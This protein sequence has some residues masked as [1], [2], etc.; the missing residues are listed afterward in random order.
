MAIMGTPG[1]LFG[2][3]ADDFTGATD[4]ANT[5]VKAG[6]RTVQ[7]LGVPR[8]GHPV[9]EADAVIVA[10]KSRSCPAPEA[11]RLSLDALDWLRQ[12]GARQ[13]YFKYC[14]TFDSTPAGN[15]G[16]VADALCDALGVDFTVFNPAF[17]TNRRTVYQG[18]L[19]VGDVLLSESSMRHHPLTP[20]N[21]PSLVRVLQQQTPRRVGLVP[22]AVVGMGAAA[23]RQAFQRLRADGVR[24]AVLDTLDD[25]HLSTLGE[26]CADLALVT[27]G[28]GMA[29][30]LPGNYLRAGLLVPGQAAGL[31]RVGGHAAVIA[32]SCSAATQAQVAHMSRT[33]ET[34]AIDPLAAAAGQDVVGDALRWA[35]S[36]LSDRPILIY[37]T[38]APEAVAAVQERLGREHAGTLVEEIL[39]QVARGLVSRGVRRLVVAGG[40]TSGAIVSALGVEGLAIGAEIDPG[41]P[42]TAS[43]GPEPLALA[44]KSGNFGTEDFFTKAFD[45]HA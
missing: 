41:V 28:S 11:V 10:L 23:V 42:W 30:G 33:H 16:P 39:S 27:G 18:Y 45:R 21:D 20:M 13:F 12:A 6:M 19:F 25:G 5:L 26:A 3:I 1:V 32:G 29:M 9:P 17:P 38:S 43:L 40:E 37:S 2:A 34:L 4:L 15:I 35:Q 31:P 8:A 44:L 7:L 36:R 24:H 22:A 14:S